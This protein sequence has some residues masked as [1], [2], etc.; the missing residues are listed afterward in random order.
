[1]ASTRPTYAQQASRRWVG[2]P[3]IAG[4]SLAGAALV[5]W[6]TGPPSLREC[7][8]AALALTGLTKPPGERPLA[9]PEAAASRQGQP[10]ETA[11]G[12]LYPTFM[13]DMV[14]EKCRALPFDREI[15]A[16]ALASSTDD[17][18]W[19]DCYAAFEA[20]LGN[21]RSRRRRR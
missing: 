4:L 17:A 19:Q 5:S 3:V 1:M 12:A 20:R 21:T 11:T 10:K 9:E 13:Y 14:V 6:N 16:C 15:L 7:Q 18:R 2:V 8:L